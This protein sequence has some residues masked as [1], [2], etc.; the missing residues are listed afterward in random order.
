M[1]VG[2]PVPCREMFARTCLPRRTPTN[3]PAIAPNGL[4]RPLVSPPRSWPRLGR[5]SP[6][7]NKRHSI[8]FRSKGSVPSKTLTECN[9]IHSLETT[10]G[11]SNGGGESIPNTPAAN[12]PV[13][14]IWCTGRTVV[15]NRG[16][17][18]VGIRNKKGAAARFYSM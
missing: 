5:M 18:T 7:C 1:S 4:F 17:M 15:K 8:N 10:I 14:G 3:G 16:C 2:L 12:V 13:I 6:R 9:H 11:T